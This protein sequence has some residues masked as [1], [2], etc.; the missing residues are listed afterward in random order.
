[1]IGSEACMMCV[2]PWRLAI[3][4]GMATCFVSQAEER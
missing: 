4:I 1:M 2:S 3:A